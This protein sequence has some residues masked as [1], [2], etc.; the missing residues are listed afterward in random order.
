MHHFKILKD[1][2]MLRSLLFWNVTQSR[3]AVTDVSV[4]PNGPVFRCQ[5]D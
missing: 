5:A 4:Q 1:V 3:L 2:F